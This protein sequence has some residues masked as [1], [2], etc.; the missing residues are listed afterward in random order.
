MNHDQYAAY[1]RKQLSL[2]EYDSTNASVN[3]HYQLGLLISIIAQQAAR[4]NE[5]MTIVEARF[6]LNPHRV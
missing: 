6:Q 1:I 2:I 4:D 5:I 3:A